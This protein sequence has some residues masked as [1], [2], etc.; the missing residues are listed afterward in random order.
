MKDKM[1]IRG[2]SANPPKD[3]INLGFVYYYDGMEGGVE[4]ATNYME[5][6]KDDGYIIVAT[7]EKDDK[8]ETI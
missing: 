8:S 6:L 1:R 3:S 2:F 7:N 5:V 4:R